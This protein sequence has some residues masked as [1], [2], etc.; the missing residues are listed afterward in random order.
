MKFSNDVQLY[1]TD[2]DVFVV[3]KGEVW[4]WEDDNSFSLID[5]LPDG[6]VLSSRRIAWDWYEDLER[7]TL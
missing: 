4:L 5:K 1:S 6:A 3:D 2:Y 7:M